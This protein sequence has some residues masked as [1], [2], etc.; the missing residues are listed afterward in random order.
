[1]NTTF[2][3]SSF[4]LH[5]LYT[6]FA[7]TFLLTMKKLILLLSI[8]SLALAAC[9]EDIEPKTEELIENEPFENE[10]VV[11]VPHLSA[12]E[13][14]AANC[15]K[16]FG[17]KFLKIANEKYIGKSVVISPLSASLLVSMVANTVDND[18]GTR[19]S[20]VLG[21]DDVEA[22]NSLSAKYMEWLPKVD[23][24]VT[25][26]IA[27]SLWYSKDYTINPAFA[28]IASGSYGSELYSRDF[29]K[30]KDLVNEINL[31][32]S[33]N[34]REKITEI[35]DHI[36]SDIF[37]IYTNALYFR[38]YWHHKFSKEVTKPQN[39]H[40]ISGTYQ[41]NMMGQQ[42]YFK[43]YSDGEGIAVELP[44]GEQGNCSIILILPDSKTDIDKFIATEGFDKLVAA[45]RK[46]EDVVLRLPKLKIEPDN[47]LELTGILE[48]LGMR[49]IGDFRK[50]KVFTN[51]VEGRLEVFQKTGM[52]LDEDGIEAASAT[53]TGLFGDTGDNPATPKYATFD[54]PFAFLIVENNT[55]LCL[56][57]GKVADINR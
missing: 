35:L 37:A 30:S 33:R 8:V 9:S 26:G 45:E 4:F 48:E 36:P 24:D 27:N 39:F 19:I 21:S 56:F 41:V 10:V 1:M 5:L 29:A 34:T 11:P 52:W 14:A 20:R 43:Y 15:Q 54:R 6:I 25:V 50:S 3:I 7:K 46:S 17:I 32:T 47:E 31:W 42:G 38:G 28:A 40:G 23:K 2:F 22:L 51:S 49:G 57:T 44:I 16:A 55:G 53:W 13:F 12:P 18:L